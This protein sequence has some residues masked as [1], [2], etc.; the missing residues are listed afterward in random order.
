MYWRF[1]TFD[2]LELCCSN[3]NCSTLYMSIN[4]MPIFMAHGHFFCHVMFWTRLWWLE[5]QG[6]VSVVTTSDQNI[7]TTIFYLNETFKTDFVWFTQNVNVFMYWRFGTLDTLE[8]CCSN[9]NCSTVL[10]FINIMLIFMPYGHFFVV[11]CFE[12]VCDDLSVKVE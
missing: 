8:L 10:V 6:R 1:G 3:W 2:T 11:A 7:L 5:C 9:F 12:H 4:S